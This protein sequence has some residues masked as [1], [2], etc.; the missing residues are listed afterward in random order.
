[1]NGAAA[2]AR[3]D[4]HEGSADD[5]AGSMSE[6][7]G[8]RRLGRG[9]SALLG[10]EGGDD[11]AKLDRLR[12][13]K[14][15]PIEQL[16]R[17]EFQPR[18]SF[19][20]EAMKTLVESVRARGIIQPILVRRRRDEANA[21]EIIAGERRWRAAQ[22]AQLHEVP[23]VIRDVT[24]REALEIAL[25]ENIQRQ[26]LTALEEAEGYGRLMEEFKHTQEELAEV[27]GKSR[28]HIANTLRLL[29]LPLD[30]Q[31]LVQSR[32]IS[33]GHARAAAMAEN[34]M[35]VARK[36]MELGLSVREAESVARGDKP[37]GVKKPRAEPEESENEPK[38]L[39]EAF[40]QTAP[41]RAKDADTLALE[42][43]LSNLLG[44]AVSIDFDGAGG[45]L[46]IYYM[47]LEQLDDVLNRLSGGTWGKT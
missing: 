11:M 9:L 3:G 31:A 42:R 21:Y 41:K 16:S 34:P 27:V 14:M 33:A 17:G 18:R 35:M 13:S 38:T 46:S 45:Q 4:D 23:V 22:E 12:A 39:A 10:E 47:S 44:L 40:A 36:V 8:K 24:D 20:D 28:S 43:S 2:Q 32:Q 15:V 25:I 5:E 1:M 19:D 7:G 37:K 6:D 26:D 29:K 30:V